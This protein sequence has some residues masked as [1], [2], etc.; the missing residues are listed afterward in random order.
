LVLIGIAYHRGDGSLGAGLRGGGQMLLSIL[1]LLI[2]KGRSIYDF[3][4]STL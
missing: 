2:Y 1:P 3:L 4:R